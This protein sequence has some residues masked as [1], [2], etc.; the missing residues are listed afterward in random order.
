M[1]IEVSVQKA[2]PAPMAKLVD[3]RDLKSLDL[4]VVPVRP[5]LGAP[6]D[7]LK[8]FH[9]TLKALPDK[10]LERFARPRK[11][12]GIPLQPALFDGINQ[13]FEL[14]YRHPYATH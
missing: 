3:A 2:S 4:T 11:P 14:L 10:G 13:P 7:H 6:F 12:L 5:R 8:T 1:P 9:K